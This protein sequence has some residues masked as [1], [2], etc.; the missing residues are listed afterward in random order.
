M[1]LK[2]FKKGVN[3]FEKEVINPSVDTY[4]V[5]EIISVKRTKVKFD[6]DWYGR[7]H[8]YVMRDVLNVRAKNHSGKIVDISFCV[9]ELDDHDFT[10]LSDDKETAQKEF[11]EFMTLKN[12]KMS[13]FHLIKSVHDTGYLKINIIDSIREAGDVIN[14]ER[15]NEISRLFFDLYGKMESYLIATKNWYEYEIEE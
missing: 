4:G 15:V 8:S 6:T 2:D 14:D 1:K 12:F 3:F 13:I 11:E 7:S 10:L 5:L 9:D